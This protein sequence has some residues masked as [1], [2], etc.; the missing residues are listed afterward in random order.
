MGNSVSSNDEWIQTV[1]Q[2]LSPRFGEFASDILSHQVEPLIQKV[3]SQSNVPNVEFKFTKL[4]FGDV[5][6]KVENVETHGT[7]EGQETTKSVTIDFDFIYVG[8]CDLQVSILGIDTGVRD[9]QMSARAR[10]VM[11]PT[12]KQVPFV[13]GLQ[14][15]FLTI[16]Q[17]GFDLDG[18]ADIIDWAPLKR[19]V[20]K[21]LQE[22]VANRCVYPNFYKIPMSSDGTNI[23]VVKAFDPT[24]V[25]IVKLCSAENLAKKGG[26]SGGLRSLVGQNL[27]DPYAKIRL[28]AT[29]YTTEEIK[30][31]QNPTWSE[32]E[33]VFLLDTVKGHNVR[34]DFYDM[35][36]FSRD[37]FLGKIVKSIADIP[38]IEVLDETMELLDDEI[39]NN[40]KTPTDVS[41]EAK[42]QFQVL[43]IRSEPSGFTNRFS[44][45][46]IFIYSFNNL[47]IMDDGNI[48]PN[49]QV[50]IQA[51]DQI[52]LSEIK[53]DSPH[54]EFQESF[55]FLL[56]Q[57]QSDE[58]N[59]TICD[60]DNGSELGKVT[61]SLIELAEESL[62]R[63]ILPINPDQPYM[64]VTL[65]ANIKYC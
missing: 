55:V 15:C 4:E 23:E 3:F 2:Q 63:K 16:P 33:N 6:P 7:P 29:V 58:I 56:K 52:K 19:K 17:I 10:L 64:T 1:I 8:N 49:S 45:A 20:I 25:L 12:T 18:I 46:S 51:G 26:L 50:T 53:K 9:V 27:P 40:S 11:K 48:Y 65:S 59:I 42:L 38:E 57:E 37:N 21:E 60:V 31:D 54:P 30:N 43:P 47:N 35:D 61:L 39:E 5:P 22:D 24:A 62:Q 14:F 36:S 13:G 28:G 44:I 41:G 32:N 34:I